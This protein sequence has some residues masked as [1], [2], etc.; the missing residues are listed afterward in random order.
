MLVPGGFV[1]EIHGCAFVPTLR[2]F[3]SWGFE[4]T[5]CRSCRAKLGFNHEADG[6]D[7]VS[8]RSIRAASPSALV[9]SGHEHAARR[10]ALETRGDILEASVC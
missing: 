5:P 9:S 3:G 10:C 6:S 2:V 1:H 4:R 8:T 7:F